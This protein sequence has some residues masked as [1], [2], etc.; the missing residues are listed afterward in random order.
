M[1]VSTVGAVSCIEKVEWWILTVLSDAS[2]SGVC[3]Y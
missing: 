2:L 1:R 3:R